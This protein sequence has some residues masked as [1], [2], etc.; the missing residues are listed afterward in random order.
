[1]NKGVLQK[2]QKEKAKY[3]ELGVFMPSYGGSNHGADALGCI[4]SAKPN[5][6]VDLGCGHNNFIKD[7]KRKGIEGVG[8]DFISQQADIIAPMHELPL[9]DGSADFITAF[10]SLEHLIPE[11]RRF[12]L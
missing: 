3:V 6:V 10:D 7:L 4:I 9:A 2:R 5:F 1:M 12:G 8:V 11:R